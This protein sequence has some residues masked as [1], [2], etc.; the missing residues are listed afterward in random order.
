M[1][2]GSSGQCSSVAAG[3]QAQS[4]NDLSQDNSDPARNLRLKEAKSF[5]QSH[6]ARSRAE[7]HVP[8]YPRSRHVLS[9]PTPAPTRISLALMRKVWQNPCPQILSKFRMLS[10]IGAGGIKRL[11]GLYMLWLYLLPSGGCKRLSALKPPGLQPG[12]LSPFFSLQ[13]QRT[14]LLLAVVPAALRISSRPSEAR[15]RLILSRS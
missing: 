14:V 1:E 2:A 11:I 4:H 9:N 3:H 12:P 8:D 13:P 5:M 7:V 6:T 10:Q 15:A